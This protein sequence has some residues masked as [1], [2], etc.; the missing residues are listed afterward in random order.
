[1]KRPRGSCAVC[2]RDVAIAANGT[3]YYHTKLDQRTM[4]YTRLISTTCRGSGKFP[5]KSRVH[6]GETG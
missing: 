4:S 1:M 6:D 3:V 5:V 2:G